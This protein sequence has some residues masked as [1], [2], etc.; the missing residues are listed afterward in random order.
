[1]TMP[2]EIKMTKAV[3]RVYLGI[4][5]AYLLQGEHDKLLTLIEEW[6]KEYN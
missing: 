1:M 4:A 3:F 6:Q 2:N 5:R